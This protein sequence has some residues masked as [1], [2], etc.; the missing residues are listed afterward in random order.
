MKKS[1]CK[2]VLLFAYSLKVCLFV[3]YFL[4]HAKGYELM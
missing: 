2:L 3:G 1:A 4:V